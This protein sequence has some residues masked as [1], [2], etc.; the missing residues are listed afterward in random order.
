MLLFT[1]CGSDPATSSGPVEE[2]VT[3]PDRSVA[4]EV[5]AEPEATATVHP[6]RAEP[7]PW[8]LEWVPVRDISTADMFARA[9][10]LPVRDPDIFA[11]TKLARFDRRDTKGAVR[12]CVDASGR[13]VEVETLRRVSGDRHVDTLVRH[14]VRRWRFDPPEPVDAAILLCTAVEFRIRF[15]STRSGGV[16]EGFPGKRIRFDEPPS[17]IPT[18]ENLA[19]ERRV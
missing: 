13:A 7:D 10:R 6:R 19:S 14:M 18:I 16:V 15:H 8:A 5:A 17:E 2:R 4:L 1:G 3:E 9:Q 12:F 11:R